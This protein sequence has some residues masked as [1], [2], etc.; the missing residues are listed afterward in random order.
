MKKM[1][2]ALLFGCMFTAFASDPPEVKKE[3][4][5]EVKFVLEPTKIF[6]D[7]VFVVTPLE[8]TTATIEIEETFVNVFHPEFLAVAYDVGWQRPIFIN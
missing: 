8:A 6:T 1:L 3:F 2:V 7:V 4:N 5:Q